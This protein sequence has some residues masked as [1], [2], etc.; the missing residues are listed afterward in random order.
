MAAHFIVK[1]KMEFADY[2]PLGVILLS[3]DRSI[4]WINQFACEKLVCERLTCFI[5]VGR[6]SSPTY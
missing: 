5:Q 3:S 6:M 2:L 1:E 4:L